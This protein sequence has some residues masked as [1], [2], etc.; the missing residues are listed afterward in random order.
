MNSTFVTLI[1]FTL[2]TF[3]GT[4][5]AQAQQNQPAQRSITQISGDLYRAQNNAH[6]NIVYVTDDGII[7]SD[8]INEEF[9]SWLKDELK[10]RFGKEVKYVLYSHY[11][12]DHASGGP[13]FNETATF[14]GHA[15]M[16]AH[17]T[18]PLNDERDANV[19]IPDLVYEDQLSIS[20]GGK[21]V[22]MHYTGKN[23][24][25]DMSVLFF[26][27]EKAVFIVDFINVKR[28][29]W[30]H[31][32]GYYPDWIESIKAVEA[33]DFEYFV[34]GHGPVGSKQDATDHRHY[35]EELIAAVT[36]GVGEGKSVEALQ[37][38]ITMDKYKNWGQYDAWREENVAGI[39][40]I[41]S[42]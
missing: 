37:K 26:P 39:F 33:L 21:T 1:S 6:Y 25:D 12:W 7:I 11:H 19:R 20:L 27:E 4:L 32:P 42:K 14:V 9:S 24:S 8:P 35:M 10:Q 23:H 3:L 41:V 40:D 29:P 18:P 16:Q 13:V 15:N 5:P 28:L 31:M 30:R 2:F 34:P 36:K 38:T 17:L 22:E